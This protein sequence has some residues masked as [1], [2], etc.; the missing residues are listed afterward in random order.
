MNMIGLIFLGLSAFALQALLTF[1]QMQNFTK[2]YQALR[3]MG[4]VAIGRRR[5][6]LRAGAIAL[7]AIDEEGCILAGRYMQGVTVLARFRTFKNGF[8]GLN[9]GA[10]TPSDCK[11]RQLASPITKAV[12]D[13]ATNYN[14]IIAGGDVPMP[15]SPLKRVAAGIS[16]WFGRLR[17]S[18]TL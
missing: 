15:A 9:V 6:A 2:H 8:E 16:D 11:E 14:T 13:A 1:V 17:T 4:R 12:L 10:L 7:F 18:T 5:G 3:R